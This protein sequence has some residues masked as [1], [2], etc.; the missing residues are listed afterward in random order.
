MFDL[1]I[2]VEKNEKFILVVCG[3]K[4]FLFMLEVMKMVVDG[5]VGLVEFYCMEG[6][7]Y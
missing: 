5:I 1:K 7:K 6:G 3:E 4:D 2:L